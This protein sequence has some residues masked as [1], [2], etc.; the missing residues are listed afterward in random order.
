MPTPIAR[1]T[2]GP[3]A[4]HVLAMASTSALSLLAV[5]M[6]DILTLVYVSRLGDQRLL[7][8]VGLAKTLMFLNGAFAAGVV[9]AG[10][11]LLSERIGK[12]G[13][14]RLARLVT[15]LLL[16]VLAVAAS[17]AALEWLAMAPLARWLGADPG[18]YASARG[19]VCMTLAAS[20]PVALAQMSAQLLKAQGHVRLALWVL[21]SGALTLAVADPLLILGLGMGL[22]GAGWSCALA[23]LVSM[24][25]GLCW[26]KRHLGL[27]LRLNPRLLCLHIGRTARLAVPAMLGN[28]AMPV[29]I[30][31]LMITLAGLGASALAGMAV[32]DRVL[33]LG[34]CVYF[35]LPTAL[36][37]VLAQN[38]GA[39]RHDRVRQA[40]AFTGRG[41]VLYGVAFWLLVLVTGPLV[42][43]YFHLQGNGRD[44]FLTVTRLGMGLWVLF[45]LDF[46]AQSLFLTLGRAWWVPTFGWLRGTLGTLPWVYA[47]AHGHGASGAV[48]GMWLGNAV[49]ALL[50]IITAWRLLRRANQ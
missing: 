20:V 40:I 4:R 44:I 29:G 14:Q 21:L 31:Y 34:Y 1:F 37:P 33:Q 49:V 26:L 10:G 24:L 41:V 28:L 25:V 18:A 15:H 46:V 2:E 9:I 27:A 38:L 23:A 43:D 5:F 11:A 7:A 47:G 13:G 39:G 22:Q 42:A 36:V 6:V 30:S 48:L 45:G 3:I 32:V 35:A 16:M 17:V 50:A 12:H 19:F 8:A